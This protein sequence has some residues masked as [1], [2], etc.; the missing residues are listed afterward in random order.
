MYTE[1]FRLGCRSRCHAFESES[2]AAYLTT[3]ARSCS[4]EKNE[5]HLRVG[6]RKWTFAGY[7]ENS[8][9]FP[10]P[11]S[12]RSVHTLNKL[13]RPRPLSPVSR[14]DRIRLNTPPGN[15]FTIYLSDTSYVVSLL[16]AFY[17]RASC[18]WPRGRHEN[19]QFFE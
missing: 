1:P 15:D 17:F 5:A 8:R 11:I 12:S 4:P 2:H 7:L 10:A 18:R 14:P 16:G 13:R 9:R 6:I 3:R 19:D